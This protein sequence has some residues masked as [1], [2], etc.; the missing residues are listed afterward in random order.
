MLKIS[1]PWSAMATSLATS[2]AM[3][4]IVSLTM[5]GAVTILAVGEVLLDLVFHPVKLG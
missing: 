5:S 4:A 2:L 1:L 3:P